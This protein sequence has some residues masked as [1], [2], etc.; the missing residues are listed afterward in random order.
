MLLALFVRELISVRELI[1]SLDINAFLT[2]P[3]G[4]ER[5]RGRKGRGYTRQAFLT[6]TKAV[7]KIASRAVQSNRC[8]TYAVIAH[9][10][11]IKSFLHLTPFSVLALV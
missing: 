3:K 8:V 1:W 5:G 10:L 7:Q 4:I 11:N 2:R 9:F 6:S